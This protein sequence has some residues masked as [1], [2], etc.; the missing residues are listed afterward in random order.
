MSGDVTPM[1]LGPGAQERVHA[2]VRTIKR[3]QVQSCNPSEPC[4]GRACQAGRAR[5]GDVPAHCCT[6]VASALGG[7]AANS[8]L[9][10]PSVSQTRTVRRWPGG[11]AWA[12]RTPVAGAWWEQGAPPVVAGKGPP[13]PTG[14]SCTSLCA[15]SSVQCT[16]PPGRELQQFLDTTVNSTGSL[17][18]RSSL[19]ADRRESAQNL[20]TG[21]PA[22]KRAAEVLDAVAPTLGNFPAPVTSPARCNHHRCS[23]KSTPWHRWPIWASKTGR[24]VAA[25]AAMRMIERRAARAW[26]AHS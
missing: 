9:C 18:I 16:G 21:G 24:N 10:T 14:Q 8:E 13:V 20:V 15:G 2:L 7:R 19:W 26:N 12:A 11:G 25:H 22:A 23:K 4:H 17:E 6:A 1:A 3:G 5:R